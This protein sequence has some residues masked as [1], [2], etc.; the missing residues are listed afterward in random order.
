MNKWTT[1]TLAKLVCSLHSLIDRK[2]VN[3]IDSLLHYHKSQH[4][5]SAS[6]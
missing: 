3:Y 1:I 2:L 4:Q 6:S 5:I